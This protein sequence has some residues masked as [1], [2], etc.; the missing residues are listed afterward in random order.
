MGVT[1]NKSAG[2]AV[3]WNLGTLGNTRTFMIWVYLNSAPGAANDNALF[4]LSN[5][6][7]SDI[8]DRILLGE[9]S[10]RYFCERSTTDGHWQYG[11]SIGTGAVKHLAITY[12]AS[13][14]TNDPIFYLNGAS[15]SISEIA[16]P[17][18]TIKTNTYWTIGDKPAGGAVISIDGYIL[19]FCGYNR[20]LSASEIA[21]AYNSRLAIPTM[22]G[23]VFATKLIGAAG[24]QVFDGATL[25]SSNT[26]A[27]HISG[28]LGTPSG[29]PV[30]RGDTYLNY[31]D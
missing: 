2:Q 27:D 6:D 24:L 11:S 19:A 9:T 28:A 3:S 31:E 26:M 4:Y 30:G 1:F 29:S 12:D 23:L 10:W 20:I 22:Q 25:T 16:T 14:T 5:S 21:N 13:L 8:D 18:G 17:V 7:G 15:V